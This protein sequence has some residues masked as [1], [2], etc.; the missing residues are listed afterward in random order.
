MDEDSALRIWLVVLILF[1]GC[2]PPT[3][4]AGTGGTAEEITA[5]ALQ[6]LAS[7]SQGQ[8][9]NGFE[10]IRPLFRADPVESL[11]S[12]YGTYLSQGAAEAEEELFQ[13]QADGRLVGFE[14]D[15]N[16]IQL[17]LACPRFEWDRRQGIEREGLRRTVES[18]LILGL[19]REREEQYR[20]AADAYL[21][22]LELAARFSGQGLPELQSLSMDLQG[23]ALTALIRL[24]GK[25]K[26]GAEELGKLA[27][28]L[29]RLPV[30][31]TD[32]RDVF[33]HSFALGKAQADYLQV[34]EQ[35]A[36]LS[37]PER[38]GETGQQVLR[39][40]HLLTRL[41]A[42]RVIVALQRYQRQF[43]HYPEKLQ[44]LVPD[45]LEAVPRDVLNPDGFFL[46]QVDQTSFLLQTASP[47]LDALDV[48]GV[49]YRH[50]PPDSHWVRGI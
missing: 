8:G 9:E 5:A 34:R 27:R 32:L 38:E 35:L 1:T 40:R 43:H 47:E 12:I 36:E 46:Y 11:S 7:S 39:F 41:E 23:R 19:H 17:S 10:R 28:R 25:D 22:A 44:E 33:D 29:S 13:A 18:C 37:L 16:E 50:Y 26:L 48:K 3:P 42:A 14:R 49:F 15:L 6:R 21:T 2:V 30:L 31:P 45:F 24:L 4:G 20:E